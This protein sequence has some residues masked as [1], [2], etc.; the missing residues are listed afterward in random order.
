MVDCS[1]YVN[2]NY[3]KAYENYLNIDNTGQCI[4][5][6]ERIIYGDMIFLNRGKWCLIITTSEDTYC[7]EV[8]L[9]MSSGKKLA[10]FF[11]D[12]AQMDCECIV[13]DNNHVLRR[14]FCYGDTPELNRNAGRL[15]CEN[16]VKLQK[17][18]DLDQL[19]EIANVSI[20]SIFE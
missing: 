5:E 14:F 10:Y 17:W 20:D 11:S 3:K 18:E 6:E 9:E 2:L 19:I 7:E 8:L 15:V 16:N 1:I 4:I 13:V 12:D